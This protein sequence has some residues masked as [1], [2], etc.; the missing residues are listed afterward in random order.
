MYGPIDNKNIRGKCTGQNLGEG[1]GSMVCGTKLVNQLAV[2][3]PIENLHNFIKTLK[4]DRL[5]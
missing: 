1:N 2:T 3:A 4:S 5:V